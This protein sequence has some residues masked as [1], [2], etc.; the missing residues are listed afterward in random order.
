MKRLTDGTWKEM[1]FPA[2][3]GP[4]EIIAAGSLAAAVGLFVT[5]VLMMLA[6]GF[7]AGALVLI[8]KV[9]R[10]VFDTDAHEELEVVPVVPRYARRNTEMI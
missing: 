7:V 10:A 5:S 1:L 6:V 2:D 4:G 8:E 9:A 3:K